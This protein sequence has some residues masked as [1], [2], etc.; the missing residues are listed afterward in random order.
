MILFLI[1]PLLL[2]S[3][4]NRT[5]ELG[6]ML[7]ES[8]YSEII[9]ETAAILSEGLDPKALS[10]RMTAQ[11]SLRHYDEAGKTAYLYTLIYCDDD[12]PK[13]D[14]SRALALVLFFY[15][16]DEAAVEAGTHLMAIRPLRKSES[17]SM[18][19]RLSDLGRHDEAD[20]IYASILPDLSRKENALLLLYSGTDPSLILASL[21]ALYAEQR[22]SAFYI[23]TLSEAIRLFSRKGWG[24]MIIPLANST[25]GGDPD[26]AIAIGDIYYMERNYPSAA[27]WWREASGQRPSDSMMRLRLLGKDG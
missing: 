12:V 11:Y 15:P 3:C 20:D 4:T 2:P 17:V 26:I 7:S 23:E 22:S 8:R 13:D 24:S 27:Q 16:D 1:L 19:M 21:E 14:M 9:E 18:Y 25:Y 6:R 5:E 10:L